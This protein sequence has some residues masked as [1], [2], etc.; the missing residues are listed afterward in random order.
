MQNNAKHSKILQNIWDRI[1]FLGND[2]DLTRGLKVRDLSKCATLALLRSR[3]AL[4][5]AQLFRHPL[6]YDP[7]L[8][9]YLSHSRFRFLLSVLSPF[10]LTLYPLAG[11]PKK[12][13]YLNVSCYLSDCVATMRIPPQHTTLK[14]TLSEERK[15]HFFFVLAVLDL[16]IPFVNYAGE[17]ALQDAVCGGGGPLAK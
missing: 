10:P 17:T 5:S 8:N 7:S 6:G 1:N 3:S 15:I 13:C 14:T 16:R 12:Y 4:P 9:H 11:T 2:V